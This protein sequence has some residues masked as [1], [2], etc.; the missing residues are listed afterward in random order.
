MPDIA[1]PKPGQNIAWWQKPGSSALA[2]AL[3]EAATQWPGV[4]LV[5]TRDTHTAHSLEA[6]LSVFLGER[7]PLLHFPDWETLPYDVFS[8]HSELIS[9]RIRCLAQLPKTTRGILVVPVTTLMQR[10][11]PRSFI[12][13]GS[14]QLRRGQRFDLAEE[15]RLLDSAG[16]RLVPNV[17]EPGEFAVRGALLDVYPMGADAPFRIELLD[18]EIDSIRRFDPETQ[19]SLEKL[20]RIDLLPGREFPLSEAATKDF[21]ARLRERFDV[22]P[23]PRTEW[24]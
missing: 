22:D 20:E 19:R 23:R 18:T 14:F 15:R 12:A 21:R 24:H 3:S 16:Y 6:G 7:L 1:F 9:A 5:V 8:P 11:A 17:Q 4:L 13:A 2:W 10:V